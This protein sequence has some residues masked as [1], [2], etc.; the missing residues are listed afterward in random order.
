MSYNTGFTS[1]QLFF[2]MFHFQLVILVLA[3]ASGACLDLE[4]DFTLFMSDFG[5][6][7]NRAEL[8][9]RYNLF[10][11]SKTMM[12][13][14]NSLPSPSFTMVINKFSAMTADEKRHYTGL[15]N[16]T[17]VIPIISIGQIWRPPKPKALNSPASHDNTA[18]G[19]VTRLKDQRSCGSCWA[20]AATAA[21]EGAYARATG[22]LKSFSEKEL[23][24][25]TYGNRDGCEGGWYDSAWGY[26]QRNRRLASYDDAP[27]DYAKDRG[28]GNYKGVVENGIKNAEYVNYVTVGRTDSALQEAS[29]SAVLAVAMV[30]DQDFFGYGSGVYDGCRSGGTVGHAVTLTGYTQ[31]YWTV[32]NSWGR[33]WG[34]KGYVR[35]SRARSNIC[36]LADYAKFPVVKSTSY[37]PQPDHPDTKEPRTRMPNTGCAFGD[38]YPCSDMNC[39]Y[40][41]DGGQC[42]AQCNGVC[43]IAGSERCGACKEWCKVGASCEKHEDC[44]KS[45]HNSCTG[46]CTI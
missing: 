44:F 43:G 38:D 42:W 8:K 13:S 16:E 18:A 4:A 11:T 45:R 35:F 40:G 31:S 17:E 23:L 1:P 3:L 37:N 32:K 19:Y 22:V 6:H 27:Y 7:Y 41:C 46:S 33:N 34:L 36:R 29:Y 9:A 20:F 24:D 5:Q 21:F 14:H 2:K 12:M 10:K 28:C 39:N 26:I 15:A 30:V 25:C